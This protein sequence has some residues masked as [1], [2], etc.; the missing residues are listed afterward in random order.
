MCEHFGM[1]PLS[2]RFNRR[3]M[4]RATAAGSLVL[5][6]GHGFA[7]TARAAE[8]H[9]KT[10]HGSGFCNLNYFLANALQTARDDGTIIDFVSTPTSAEMVTFLGSGQVDAGLMPY[11]SFIAC[12][13]RAP[14]SPSSPAAASRGWCW[15]PNPDW[16]GRRS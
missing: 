12:T 13:T 7:G 4:L 11:T 2:A 3:G 1:T 6:M 16:T 8:T 10:I 14:P 9:I 15:S 5:A